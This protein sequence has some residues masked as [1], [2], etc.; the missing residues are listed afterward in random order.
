MVFLILMEKNYSIFNELDAV[1]YIKAMY[2]KGDIEKVFKC[3]N[4]IYDSQYGEADTIT[5]KIQRC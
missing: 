3:P 4:E 1:V 5:L 2:K